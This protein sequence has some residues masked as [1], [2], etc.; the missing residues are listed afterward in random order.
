VLVT[1]ATRYGS[2]HQVAETIAATLR[3]RGIEVELQSIREV[4]TLEPYHAIVIGAPLY[5]GRWPK[6]AHHFLSRHRDALAQRPTMIFAV[7]PTHADPKEFEGARSQLVLE[8]AKY[9]WLNPEKVEIF[10][11]VYDPAKLRFPDNLLTILPASPL[12]KAPAS[13][14]RDW[15]AIRAWADKLVAEL[16]IA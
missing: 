6:E 5:I 7:G 10:G 11:G 8:L 15:D 12:Y 4:Q 13:D 9:P 1:Y 16:Q 3:E 2:T 14:V